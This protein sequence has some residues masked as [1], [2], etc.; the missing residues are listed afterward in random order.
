ME[1]EEDDALTVGWNRTDEEGGGATGVPWKELVSKMED[2]VRGEAVKV[3]DA[4][5]AM[6]MVVVVFKL[7]KCP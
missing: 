4:M 1:T 6:V 3:D 2:L 7:L 5:V